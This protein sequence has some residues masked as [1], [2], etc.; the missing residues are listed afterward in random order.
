M[1]RTVGH[2]VG[3]LCLTSILG[4]CA[5]RLPNLPKGIE[6]SQAFPPPSQGSE[7]RPYIIGRSDRIAVT[8]FREE[9]LSVRDLQVDTGGNVNLPLIGEVRAIDQTA[10]ALA[11][12]VAQLYAARYL[13]NPQVSVV[14]QQAVSQRVTVIG[15][16]IDPGIYAIEGRTTLVN[17]LAMAKG[18]S[19]VAALDNAVIFR[20]IGGK[21][22]GAIFNMKHISRGEAF[23]PEILGNDIVVVG[24]STI[25]AAWR[26][27]LTAAPLLSSIAIINNQ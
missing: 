21:Q 15:S 10:P 4:G 9:D 22:V 12:R 26:D 7:T 25:K 2:L 23:D 8:V 11:A 27:V 3:L 19:R 13:V 16:V 5:N 17:A 14:V 24:H 6:S 20:E 18:A 1:T